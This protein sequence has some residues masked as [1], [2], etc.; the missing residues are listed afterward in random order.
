MLEGQIPPK[1]FNP[2]TVRHRSAK[3]ADYILIDEARTPLIISESV[4]A[5]P[6]QFQAGKEVAT[7]LQKD[8]HYTVDETWACL[9][10]TFLELS[11]LQCLGFRI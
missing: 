2:Q 6:R 4:P 8:L 11:R 10:L 9:S 1:L 3:E 5:V 7:A